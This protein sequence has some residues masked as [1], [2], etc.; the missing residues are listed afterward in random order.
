LIARI[1][2]YYDEINAD[3]IIFRWRYKMDETTVG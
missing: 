3:P 1:H 2:L